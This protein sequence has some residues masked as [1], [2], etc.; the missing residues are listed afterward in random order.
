MKNLIETKTNENG[1]EEFDE[2]NDETLLTHTTVELFAQQI[3]QIK[4]ENQESLLATLK[5]ANLFLAKQNLNLNEKFK[6]KLYLGQLFT[7]NFLSIL[8]N[9]LSKFN[10]FILFYSKPHKLLLLNLNQFDQLISLIEPA[11]Y[12]I[13][14]QLISQIKL[15][16]AEFKDLSSLNILFKFYGIF[17]YVI[18]NSIINLKQNRQNLFK[19]KRLIKSSKHLFNSLINKYN[20]VNKNLN[21]IFTSFT[22]TFKNTHRVNEEQSNI[23]SALYTGFYR[24]LAQYI[25]EMPFNFLYG[26][27]LL[28]SYLPSPLPILLDSKIDFCYKT[29]Q[30]KVLSERR[31]LSDH[32]LPLFLNDKLNS[33]NLF[34]E[35]KG[36]NHSH[37]AFVSMIR[38]LCLTSTKTK[39]NSLFKRICVQLCD[40]SDVVCSHLLRTLLDYAIEL[41]DRIK[42]DNDFIEIEEGNLHQVDHEALVKMET[43]SENDDSIYDTNPLYDENM[44]LSEL[45]SDEAKVVFD[46]NENSRES[47]SNFEFNNKESE[48][49]FHSKANDQIK[50]PHKTEIEMDKNFFKEN[51]VANFSRLIKFLSSL[52]MIDFKHAELNPIRTQFYHLISKTN[53]SVKKRNYVYF[54]NDAIKYC[55]QIDMNN[56]KSTEKKSNHHYPV[57]E[58]VL[59]LVETIMRYVPEF[60]IENIKLSN[61]INE[62][63]GE[64]KKEIIL[65]S[66]NENLSPDLE[67][68][69]NLITKTLLD[70]LNLNKLQSEPVNNHVVKCLILLNKLHKSYFEMN[71]SDFDKKFEQSKVSL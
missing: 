36:D 6:K 46:L 39:L 1:E 42:F 45:R 34:I 56:L 69:L 15:R 21:K 49:N 3:S 52:L 27:N 13:K 60:F 7:R 28:T 63:T 50:A 61:F 54:L 70:H 37:S 9:F 58:S 20:L 30:A 44:D 71:K 18:Q 31:I 10:D 22:T 26:L 43:K 14:V 66:N 68:T 55:N 64:S 47:D 4:S 23:R 35:P 51:L 8:L 33:I 53:S 24:E 62:D 25:V 17:N 38:I 57:Q 65:S 59:Y 2:N 16:K 41:F 5:S 48:I 67:L 32:L 11:I 12:L 40:V 29:R 19:K